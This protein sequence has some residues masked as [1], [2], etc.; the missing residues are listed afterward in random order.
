VTPYDAAPRADYHSTISERASAFLS[1]VYAWMCAGLLVTAA[2][3][4][5]IAGSPAAVAAIAGN[6]VLFWGL[7][8]AQFGIVF[9]LSARVQ[10]LAAS[11]AALLFV[12][13]AAITGALL[14]FVLL[15]YTGESVASTFVVTAGMFAGLAAYGT[16]TKRDLDGVGQ[17]LFMGL[18]GIVLA[19]FVGL[20]VHSDAFQFVLSFV[21]VIVFSGLAAYDAQRLK[22]MA[23]QT[24]DGQSSSYAI[25]GALALYLDF[26]NLFLFMLRFTGVRREWND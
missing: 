8:I 9:A 18:L 1:A 21:G 3:A 16:L 14:S 20:F 25:A 7:V 19:S 13:Y 2:T 23:L 10:Q 5:G 26:T 6:R 12:A 11:S 15:A 22:V 24:A 17:F 4:W